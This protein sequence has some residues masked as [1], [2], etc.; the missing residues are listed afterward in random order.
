MRNPAFSAVLLAGGK[1]T[2]MGRDKAGVL[3]DGEPMWQRQ[4]AKLKA[5]RPRKIFISGDRE[6]PYAGSGTQ[7]IEDFQVDCGP[8]AGIEAACWRME[9]PLL[10]VLAIDL[11]WMTSEFLGRLVAQ[12][13]STG[14]GVVPRNGENFEPLAAVYPSALYPLI[15]EQLNGTDH[16]MQRLI[17]RAVKM[18][19]VVAYSIAEAERALFRNVNTPEDLAKIQPGEQPG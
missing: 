17:R 12:A 8:L 5:I 2:R 4:L 19:L 10:C 11:P 13:Q 9:T 6:G 15:A 14:C 1:S 18:K 3:V 16:S 7:I